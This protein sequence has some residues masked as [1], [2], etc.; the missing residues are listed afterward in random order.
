MP[1]CAAVRAMRRAISPRLAIRRVLRGVMVPVG[2]VEEVVRAAVEVFKVGRRRDDGDGRRGR[3]R[4]V[5]AR[6]RWWV[7]LRERIVVFAV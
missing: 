7:R 5:V 4:D 3:E 1:I 2:G 6:K